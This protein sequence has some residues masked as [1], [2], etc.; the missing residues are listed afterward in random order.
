MNK[1]ILSI[2]LSTALLGQTVSLVS[3][4]PLVIREDD[5]STTEKNSLRDKE[6]KEKKH[7]PLSTV[8]PFVRGTLLGAAI[9]TTLYL[10]LS[11]SNSQ[12][13][14]VLK[15]TPTNCMPCGEVRLRAI[16][17]HDTMGGFISSILL[18]Y[19]SH[20]YLQLIRCFPIT[21]A[22]ELLNSE[23]FNPQ[24]RSALEA[25]ICLY[26]II[27]A[28]YGSSCD[29]S[30]QPPQVVT[31]NPEYE[32]RFID[33]LNAFCRSSVDQNVDFTPL[34][35]GRIHTPCAQELYS[36]IGYFATHEQIFPRT[37]LGGWCNAARGVRS[38]KPL[39]NNSITEHGNVNL[40]I[41][42]EFGNYYT[43]IYI[44]G[45]DGNT[46]L[47]T[48]GNGP[49]AEHAITD[50]QYLVNRRSAEGNSSFGAPSAPPAEMFGRK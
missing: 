27:T 48:I 35:Y 16:E 25:M 32:R 40:R 2:V 6:K 30:A 17:P 3:A 33:K 14:V 31:L 26:E 9:P 49:D 8:R 24:T 5:Y 21:Q 36:L 42:E 13:N 11:G 22:K 41:I 10:L 7:A 4:K 44:T 20:S 12:Q 15:Q 39:R 38:E 23:D 34:K 28:L 18:F 29:P 37:Y 1:K 47:W 46:Y 43:Q 19:H 50:T 45:T